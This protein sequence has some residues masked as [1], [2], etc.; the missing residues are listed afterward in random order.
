MGLSLIN[1]HFLIKEPEF[2]DLNNNRVPYAF[3]NIDNFEYPVSDFDFFQGL[4]YGEILSVFDEKLKWIS[5][6]II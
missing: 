1:P 4:C 3:R 5:R 6:E 2:V